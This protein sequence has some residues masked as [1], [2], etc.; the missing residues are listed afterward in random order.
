MVR[1]WWARAT[2]A[3]EPKSLSRCFIVDLSENR[4]KKKLTFQWD[5]IKQNTTW[6]ERLD[7]YFKWLETLVLPKTCFKKDLEDLQYCYCFECVCV[8]A[9]WCLCGGNILVTGN[10]VVIH[11]VFLWSWIDSGEETSYAPPPFPRKH[12]HTHLKCACLH[13]STRPTCGPTA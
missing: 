9:A 8:C 13:F 3:V 7:S 5:S 6:L 2:S 12:S 11:N 10:E 1:V 4:I